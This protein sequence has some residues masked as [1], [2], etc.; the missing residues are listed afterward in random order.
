MD[1][2]QKSPFFLQAAIPVIIVFASAIF[3]YICGFKR[4]QEP[5]FSKLKENSNKKLQAPNSTISIR[6]PSGKRKLVKNEDDN[7]TDENKDNQKNKSDIDATTV[8]AKKESSGITSVGSKSKSTNNKRSIQKQETKTLNSTKK[9][10]HQQENKKSDKVNNLVVIDD[11]WQ[12]VTSRN[13]KKTKKTEPTTINKNLSTT[14][15]TT[16]STLHE[17][18]AGSHE[19]KKFKEKYQ[20]TKSSAP[21]KKQAINNNIK[22]EKTLIKQE[23]EIQTPKQIKDEV[24]KS[25]KEADEQQHQQQQKSTIK[26]TTTTITINSS[27]GSSL[28]IPKHMTKEEL[29]EFVKQISSKKNVE[30]TTK[31]TIVQDFE[32]TNF[33]SEPIIKVEKIVTSSARDSSNKKDLTA[34]NNN[35]INIIGETKNF[36]LQASNEFIPENLGK[37]I[38]D[39]P[40]GT[41]KS[42]SNNKYNIATFFNEEKKASNLEAAPAVSIG[43][44]NVAFDEL[45]DAWTEAAPKKSKK[46]VR[47][48]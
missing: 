11:G 6:K 46:R 26:T 47:K 10:K 36:L 1:L 34:I 2:F 16:E 12:T 13:D 42:F 24:N 5:K 38:F 4:P 37:S 17:Y 14:N 20:Q 3:V 25:K 19:L 33:N 30:T 18:L 27:N 29:E 41:S 9:Q 15:I 45:A 40:I 8:A 32:K 48:E 43:S 31:T 28:E 7:L 39:D 23:G 22:N 44:S 35:N 21:T